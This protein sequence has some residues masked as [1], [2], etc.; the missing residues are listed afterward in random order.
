MPNTQE[1]NENTI[2]TSEKLNNSGALAET[3][4]GLTI[5]DAG[6]YYSDENDEKGDPASNAKVATHTNVGKKR[7]VTETSNGNV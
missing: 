1:E 4:K 5:N 2:L 7:K 3:L 6:Y